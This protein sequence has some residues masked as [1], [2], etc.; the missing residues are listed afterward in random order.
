MLRL[1]LLNIFLSKVCITNNSKLKVLII[2][3]HFDSFEESYYKSVGKQKPKGILYQ[4]YH[5]TLT[6]L[7][8]HNL[9]I[10]SKRPNDNSVNMSSIN[11]ATFNQ[12]ESKLQKYNKCH[13]SF[14]YS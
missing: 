9:W 3:T 7:H 13:F 2:Q 4:K 12:T 11:E 6:E 8:R 10:P 1:K 14:M 5:N